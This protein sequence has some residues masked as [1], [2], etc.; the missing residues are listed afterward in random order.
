VIA[1]TATDRRA[2]LVVI[3]ALRRGTLA[4]TVGST[5]ESVA[6]DVSCDVLLVPPL[7]QGV[8]ASRVVRG[9][10]RRAKPHRRPTSSRGTG[11]PRHRP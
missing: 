3:G 6:M 8:A 7:G 2:A 11:R 9:R 5:T 10:A 1:R 4:Q